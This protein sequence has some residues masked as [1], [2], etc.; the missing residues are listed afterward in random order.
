MILSL[1]ALPWLETLIEQDL[2]LYQHIESTDAA[3]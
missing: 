2:E 3:V 1:R